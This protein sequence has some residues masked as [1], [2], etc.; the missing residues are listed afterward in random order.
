[1]VRSRGVRT[2]P[3]DGVPERFVPRYGGKSVGFQRSRGS[4]HVTLGKGDQEV[5]GELTNRRFSSRTLGVWHWTCF[6]DT[7]T[8]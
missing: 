7:R 8:H 2:K 3:T 6:L 1:M 5:R 4:Q